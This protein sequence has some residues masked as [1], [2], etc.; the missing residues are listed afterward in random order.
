MVISAQTWVAGKWWNCKSTASP[1]KI[2]LNFCST[3]VVISEK[4]L[5][6][7]PFDTLLT[8]SYNLLL[9]TC[10]QLLLPESNEPL[11]LCHNY[12]CLGSIVSHLESKLVI[13]LKSDYPIIFYFFFLIWKYMRNCTNKIPNFFCKLLIVGNIMVLTLQVE[14]W[15]KGKSMP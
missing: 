15:E 2:S 4:C 3:D 7:T 1:Q 12:F 10:L 6:T 9:L 11:M 8:H 14:N 5:D 13:F